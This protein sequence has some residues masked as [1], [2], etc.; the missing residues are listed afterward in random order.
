MQYIEYIINQTIQLTK[1]RK[2]RNLQQISVKLGALA[3][4]KGVP[5]LRR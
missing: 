2:Q 3:Q 4:A 5:S 1:C